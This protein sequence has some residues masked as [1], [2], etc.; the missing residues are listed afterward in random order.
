MTKASHPLLHIA[1]SLPTPSSQSSFQASA[2]GPSVN[3]PLKKSL[4][5][6]GENMSFLGV[7]ITK[8]VHLNPSVA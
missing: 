3:T 2:R 4:H 5:I 6:E 8:H 1:T 7:L